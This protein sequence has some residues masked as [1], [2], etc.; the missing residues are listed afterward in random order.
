MKA[1][2]AGFP[3]A[4]SM[5]NVPVPAPKFEA[6]EFVLVSLDAAD[7]ESKV[8]WAR[9]AA[10]AAGAMPNARIRTNVARIL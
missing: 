5:I 3:V 8:Y 4:V 7:D 1:D 10:L 9:I 6:T 2:G